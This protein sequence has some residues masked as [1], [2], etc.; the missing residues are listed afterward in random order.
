[1]THSSFLIPDSP[2]Q[3]SGINIKIQA[4][5]S[6]NKS[7]CSILHREVP[8]EGILTQDLQVLQ[9]ILVSSYQQT[10]GHGVVVEV[11]CLPCVDEVHHLLEDLGIQD[12]D[13]N[14]VLQALLQ[15]MFKQ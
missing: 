11:W 6:H 14:A 9:A 3:E 12:M 10:S 1:M 13:L 4:T 8:A 2:S 5:Q 15:F 7:V